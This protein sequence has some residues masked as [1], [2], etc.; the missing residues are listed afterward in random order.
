MGAETPARFVFGRAAVELPLVA[1]LDAL[2]ATIPVLVGGCGSGRTTTLHG[3]RRRLGADVCQYIDVERIATTPERF[4][5]AVVASSPFSAQVA[6][7]QVRSPRDAYDRILAFLATARCAAGQPATFL[8]DEFLELRTFVSFPGLRHAVEEL[9]RVLATSGNRFVLTSRYAA[10]V[11]RLLRAGDRPFVRFEA[12]PFAVSDVRS[13]LE[14]VARETPGSARAQGAEAEFDETSRIVHLLS[15]GHPACVRTIG[16]ALCVQQRSGGGDPVSALAAALAPD[17]RLAERCLHSY[18]IR[19]HRARGYGALK[20][21]L[22]ILA[23]EEPLTLTDIA[24]RL[25]RTPGSTKDYLSWLE[26]VDLITC[27]QK[28]YGFSDPVLRLWV[29]LYFRPVPPTDDIVAR[30]IQQFVFDRLSLSLSGT[31]EAAEEAVAGGAA[32]RSVHA[33][34]STASG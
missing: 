23:E 1:A 12:I 13:L 29:R 17:G 9:L 19:L 10:R 30:E 27:T 3:L 18:E 15:G 21:I 24:K 25:A 34:K 20:A 7:R 4:L 14:G 26:D 11:A 31:P 33:G 8:L 2:P 28:Q 22:D 6:G 5:R 32:A 16:E